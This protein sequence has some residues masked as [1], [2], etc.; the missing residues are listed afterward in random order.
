MCPLSCWVYGVLEVKPRVLCMPGTHSTHKATPVGLLCPRKVASHLSITVDKKLC[1][2]GS[3][4]PYIPGRERERQ[5]EFKASLFYIVISR[6][7]RVTYREPVSD[8]ATS[9]YGVKPEKMLPSPL[10]LKFPS[11][12]IWKT[13]ATNTCAVI[14]AYHK[15]FLSHREPINTK[16][17]WPKAV[18]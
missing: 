14:S 9:F 1:L 8:T 11:Q 17:G 18:L 2:A 15:G 12:Q 7:A 5:V 16:P 4:N 13:C 3:G 6:I 10:T